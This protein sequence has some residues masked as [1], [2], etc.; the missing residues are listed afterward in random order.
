[1]LKAADSKQPLQAEEF[2]DDD[3]YKAPSDVVRRFIIACSAT[4]ICLAGVGLWLVPAEDSAGQLIKLFASAIMLATGLFLFNGLNEKSEAAAIEVDPKKRQLRV[5]EYDARG[6]SK[7]KTCYSIDDLH[8]VSVADRR[9]SASN[10]DGVL[11][12]EMPIES[13]AAEKA[14]RSAISRAS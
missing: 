5:Y 10:S 4:A 14:L 9:L 12:L 2:L 11:I 7:L 13:D 3:P 6:R 8:D 1:M